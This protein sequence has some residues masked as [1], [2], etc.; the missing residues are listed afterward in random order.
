MTP[1]LKI[2]FDNQISKNLMNKLN[3]KQTWSS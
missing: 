2:N 3:V 1:R